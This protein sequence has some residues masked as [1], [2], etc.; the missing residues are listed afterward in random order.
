MEHTKNPAGMQ[1]YQ[2]EI[3][4]L[5]LEKKKKSTNVS[6]SVGHVLSYTKLLNLMHAQQVPGIVTC[7]CL[8]TWQLLEQLL[9][10]RVYG[11]AVHFRA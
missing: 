2:S 7:I 10:G 9:T 8:T 11:M 4:S 5:L 1:K 3:L 6:Q